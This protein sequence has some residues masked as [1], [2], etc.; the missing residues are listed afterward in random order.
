MEPG[1]V[2]PAIQSFCQP[3]LVAFLAKFH[4]SGKYGNHSGKHKQIRYFVFSPASYSSKKKTYIDASVEV[5]K[6]AKILRAA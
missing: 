5:G 3:I 2:N 6:N 4:P 1:L